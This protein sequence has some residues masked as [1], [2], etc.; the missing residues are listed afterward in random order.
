MLQGLSRVHKPRRQAESGLQISSVGPDSV[1][2]FLRRLIVQKKCGLWLLSKH[3]KFY[4][5][6]SRILLVGDRV[7]LRGCH[8]FLVGR[9]LLHSLPVLFSQAEIM[10]LFAC[11]ARAGISVCNSC[12]EECR[13]YMEMKK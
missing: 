2:V 10:H 3:M 5:Q 11:P 1:L 6:W 4:D 13:R 8:P 9:N 12:E 7:K